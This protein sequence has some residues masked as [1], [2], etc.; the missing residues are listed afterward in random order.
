MLIVVLILAGTSAFAGATLDR[1][2]ERGEIR[3]GMTGNQPPLSMKSKSGTLIGFE[4]DLANL[5]GQAMEVEPKLVTK[6]FPELIPALLAGEIDVIISGMTITPQRN[7]KV[8]FV[9]PYNVTGKSILT[10]SS[11]LA[12]AQETDE[13]NAENITLTALKGSTS[14]RFVQLLLPKAKLTATDDYDAAVKMV[15]DGQANALVADIEVCQFSMLRYP[16]AGLATLAAPLTIEPIGIALPPNDPLL[17][18]LIQNY[19][20]TLEGLEL[21]DELRAKWY[22]DGSWLIQIP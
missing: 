16:D 9:G 19:L 12:A 17:M 18:N 3:I 4:V 22:E 20:G 10:K 14:E 1:I 7:T 5:L 8:A 6:P 2:V 21:L 13:I 11:T 15:L